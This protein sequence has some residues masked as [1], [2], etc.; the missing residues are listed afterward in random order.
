MVIHL[1]KKGITM[2]EIS[3]LMEKMY[4][5]HYTSQTI[6][7]MTKAFSETVEA[8]HN[9][10]TCVYLDATYITVRRDTF[11]KEA[12]HITIGIRKDDLK[13]VLAYTITPTESA[14]NW[15]ELLE[16]LK[17]RGV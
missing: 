10:H 15:K 6:S 9:R 13:E 17:D 3:S 8:L 11:S 14:H 2:A 4:G 16:E 7:N 5:H 1:F 12:V